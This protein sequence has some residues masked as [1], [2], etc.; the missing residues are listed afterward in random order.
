M[1][2]ND[3][4]TK[5]NPEH[6]CGMCGKKHGSRSKLDAHVFGIGPH[7]KATHPY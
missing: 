7:S 3:K 1:G 2:N 5:M 4:Y 6:K